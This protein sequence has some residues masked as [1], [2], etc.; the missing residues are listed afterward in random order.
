MRKDPNKI[1]NEIRE[2]TTNTTEIQMIIREY[3]EKFYARN[4]EPG[5][6]IYMYK[7]MKNEEIEI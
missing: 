4:L 7:T 2:I 1:T 3:D 5:R 6:H